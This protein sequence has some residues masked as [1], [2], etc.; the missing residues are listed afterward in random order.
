[1]GT[2]N[3]PKD[4]GTEWQKMKRD[5]KSNFTSANSRKAFQSISNGILHVYN[6]L[7]LHAGAFF[8]SLYANGNDSLYIGRHTDG[9]G[10][11]VEGMIITRPNGALAFWTYGTPAGDSFW[12][13]YDK[14]D[15]IIMSDDAVSGQ[16]IGRPWIPYN[17]VRT[18]LL[19]T[20]ADTTTSTSYVSHHTISGVMQH[21]RISIRAYVSSQTSPFT[22]GAQIRIFDPSTGTQ[23]AQSAAT[24]N[25]WV[26]L[27]GNHVN[28]DFGASFVYDIQIR[29]TSG[30]G[31]VGTTL[32]YASGVQS[33]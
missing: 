14:Q 16:G 25:N 2:P 24:V 6:G 20:P 33:P 13:M 19:T 29:R 26:D 30:S 12:A 22:D 31:A 5:I 32:V 21:P 27:V 23:I 17:T 1:M 15:H 10:H 3:Y 18:V 9:S 8:R 11:D 4:M 7:L 28:Y